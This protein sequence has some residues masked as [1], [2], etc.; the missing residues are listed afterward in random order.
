M[1]AIFPVK[2]FTKPAA[3]SSPS[4]ETLNHLRFGVALVTDFVSSSKFPAVSYCFSE[5]SRSSS[6][7]TWPSSASRSVFFPS[8]GSAWMV[9]TQFVIVCA[10]WP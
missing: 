9:L 2:S 8:S 5:G 1:A 3:S 6:A 10:T 7:H 4:E